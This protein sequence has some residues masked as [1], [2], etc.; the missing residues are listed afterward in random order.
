MSYYFFNAR[1]IP[2][3]TELEPV[4]HRV[5]ASGAV[6]AYQFI[7]ENLTLGDYHTPYIERINDFV[8]GDIAE[9]ELETD[10]DGAPILQWVLGEPTWEYEKPTWH[11]LTSD[12][13][14]SGDEL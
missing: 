2:N 10:S 4:E 6:Q 11:T 1:L 12:D 3:D 14:L 8:T 9:F 5:I 7:S 13:W